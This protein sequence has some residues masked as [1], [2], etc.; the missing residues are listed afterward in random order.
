MHVS[1][2]VHSLLTLRATLCFC[3]T[4]TCTTSVDFDLHADTVHWKR[5][6]AAQVQSRWVTDGYVRPTLTCVRGDLN[7]GAFANQ[8]GL[9]PLVR[10]CFVTDNFDS[11][12]SCRT[13]VWFMLRTLTTSALSSRVCLPTKEGVDVWVWQNEAKNMYCEQHVIDHARFRLKNNT[14]CQ[15]NIRIC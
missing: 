2:H 14:L 12:C 7:R 4:S 1:A 9:L 5:F 13:I 11:S 8:S 15:P 6:E 10:Q 3:T